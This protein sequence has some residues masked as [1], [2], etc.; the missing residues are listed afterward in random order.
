MKLDRTLI[1]KDGAPSEEEAREFF[2]KHDYTVH[3]SSFDPMTASDAE[4]RLY[5]KAKGFFRESW[6]EQ[7]KSMGGKGSMKNFT[8]NY[9][10]RVLGDANENLI[11]GTV[12]GILSDEEAC[13]K[14]IDSFFTTM[15]EPLTAG[16]NAFA[17]SLKKE[18]DELSETEIKEVVDKVVNLFLEE[19]INI[20]M[21]S[22]GVPDLISTVKRNGAHEDFSESVMNNYDKIDFDRKWY[23]LRTK[24]GAPLSLDELAETTPEALADAEAF[25]KDNEKEYIILRRKFLDT[26]NSAD[27]EIYIMLEN[28]C[29][30]AEIAERLGYK[31]HSAI[32]KREK[33]IKQQ[34]KEFCSNRNK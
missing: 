18:P 6:L 7:L 27:R 10:L 8:K 14:I 13:E 9:P 26:L 5:Q 32:T 12:M 34:V 19:M 29:T 15:E 23:H 4:L 16:F 24:L 21:K 17:K 1:D 3:K 20:Q 2:L 11:A 22:Q 25:F 28:E 33:K 31:T 30:Q